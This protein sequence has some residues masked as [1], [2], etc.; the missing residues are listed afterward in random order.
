[1]DAMGATIANAAVALATMRATAGGDDSGESGA[2][3]A[4]GCQNFI[5]VDALEMTEVSCRISVRRLCSRVNIR[6]PWTPTLFVAVRRSY[7]VNLR[8]D[9]N[10]MLLIRSK[11]SADNT[12]VLAT[13]HASLRGLV[14]SYDRVLW[15][16]RKNMILYELTS[17]I[18][19]RDCT[20][21]QRYLQTKAS[22][23]MENYL[24]FAASDNIPFK[25]ALASYVRTRNSTTTNFLA[26]RTTG[27]QGNHGFAANCGI[28]G[29]NGGFNL[30]EVFEM[31]S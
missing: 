30:S 20:L 6:V 19:F 10:M 26:A 13:P 29:G 22:N 18:S 5:V 17:A 25:V 28:A 23:G 1:M 2:S 12:G 14:R 9:I 16:E 15:N 24:L 4:N 11:V 27:T 31:F 3:T 8:R 21:A 7:I